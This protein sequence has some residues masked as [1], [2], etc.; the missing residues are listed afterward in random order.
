MNNEIK[1][2]EWYLDDVF[3]ELRR[4]SLVSEPAI[5]EDFIFFGTQ[6]LMFKTVDDEKR[7]VTGPIMIPDFK[8]QRLDKEGNLY[9]GYFSKETVRKAALLFFKKGSNVNFTNLEH[10]V[11]VDGIYFFESWIVDD[12][13]VDKSKT[14]GFKVP[15]GTWM[16]SAKIEN[17]DVWN[18]YIKTGLVKGFSVEIKSSEEEVTIL[19]SIK[20]YIEKCEL[21]D[22]EKLEKIKVLLK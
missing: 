12:P 2:V 13:D 8:I 20:N 1:L 11:E 10:Q 21:T 15:V 22:D 3:S 4:I 18:Q 14:M 19:N 16:G 5:E 6:D 9:Y 17:D 7:I